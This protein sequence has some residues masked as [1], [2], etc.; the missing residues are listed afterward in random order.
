MAS[1]TPQSTADFPRVR[2]VRVRQD[3]SVGSAGRRIE[4]L[5]AAAHRSVGS[6][7]GGDFDQLCSLLGV[8]QLVVLRHDGTE[9]FPRN[10]VDGT[11]EAT[12]WAS[13]SSAFIRVRIL[14]W[15]GGPVAPGSG[16]ARRGYYATS[17]RALRGR[18][19]RGELAHGV[20]WWRQRGPSGRDQ[21]RTNSIAGRHE[22]V[23]Q[24][25]GM[26]ALGRCSPQLE[27]RS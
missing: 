14:G 1:T 18:R 21:L 7:T 15:K 26:A 19:G 8:D 6:H 2:R 17:L 20:A 3:L 12:F 25:A 5:E 23:D 13:A 10:S 27:E 22:P 4:V 16:L 9:P 11:A 24:A